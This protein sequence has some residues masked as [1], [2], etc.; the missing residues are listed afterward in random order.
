MYYPVPDTG[1][2]FGLSNTAANVVPTAS[3]TFNATEKSIVGYN[4]TV[5]ATQTAGTAFT[6]TLTPKDIA[7]NTLSALSSGLDDLQGRR[8]ILTGPANAPN[9]NVP[10]A[11]GA[12]ITG[13]KDINPNF[14]AALV[15]TINVTLLRKE[16]IAAGAFVLEDNFTTPRK[17]IS[18]NAIAVQ[19][20]APSALQSAN[21]PGVRA[22]QQIEIKAY[23]KDTYGNTSFTGC[24]TGTAN[25]LYGEAAWKST[26]GSFSAA[27]ADVT[28]SGVFTTTAGKAP[29]YKTLAA[30][31]ADVTSS[32]TVSPDATN[33]DEMKMYVT[34]YKK[35]EN[36]ISLTACAK[37]LVLPVDVIEANTAV[38]A[39]ITTSATRPTVSTPQS[40]VECLHSGANPTSA[41]VV[42]PT[43][44][45]YFWDTYGNTF[46]DG[47]GQCSWTGAKANAADPTTLPSIAGSATSLQLT[48]SGPVNVN[49]T[50]TGPNATSASLLAF[51]GI[52]SW[53]ANVI[54]K[55]DQQL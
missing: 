45:S 24:G 35:G 51:G 49:L 29:E 30:S 1:I 42:C 21:L 8:F 38:L 9:G 27:P 2:T 20:A 28:P 25:G 10:I 13:E 34:L 23:L 54:P 26:G 5:G 37:T 41:E 53:Q 46:A 11:N 43:I 50:C 33:S 15:G 39:R 3:I 6:V 31:G 44:Y 7:G 16:T 36:R 19:S 22:G 40:E 47:T 52:S 18:T 17:A 12:A 48:H 32:A 14:T 4:L 55:L